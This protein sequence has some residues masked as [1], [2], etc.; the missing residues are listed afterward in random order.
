M[1]LDMIRDSV[2]KAAAH[3]VVTKAALMHHVLATG[4]DPDKGDA[5]SIDDRL[6]EA[7]LEEVT[8]FIES[9]DIPEEAWSKAMSEMDMKD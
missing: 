4:G 3:A 9:G 6:M 2:L 5:D 7:L 8:K 1:G